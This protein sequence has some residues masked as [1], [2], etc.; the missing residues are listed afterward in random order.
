MFVL[1]ISF[2][3]FFNFIAS[4]EQDKFM[5]L[6]PEVQQLEIK[7]GR[8][9]GFGV[10][11]EVEVSPD[12]DPSGVQEQSLSSIL[13][14]STNTSTLS[15][16]NDN[17]FIFKPPVFET[18]GRLGGTFN[19]SKISTFGSPSVHERL[20]GSKGRVPKIQNSLQKSVNFQDMFGS[21]FHQAN[22]MNIS[23]PEEATGSSSRVL[24][25]R[26]HFDNDPESLS[27]D[28]EQNRVTTR[29]RNTSPY[30][31][32]ITAN[33]IF[34]TPSSKFGLSDVPSRGLQENGSSKTAVSIRENGTW[35]IS[36]SDDPMD[37]SR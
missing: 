24:P 7:S 14:P 28:K 22:A 29:V 5:D 34:N 2:F 25:N 10:N 16:R 32:R 18:P 31:R 13:I 4:N 36:S 15:Q 11:S 17:N 20:F 9:P 33:P 8:S 37:I 35:N 23:P 12:A 30:S 3:F 1:V 26:Q 19:H 6:L 21:G 27:P